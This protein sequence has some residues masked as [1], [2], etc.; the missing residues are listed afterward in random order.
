MAPSAVGRDSEL[1]CA[2]KK[3]PAPVAVK[4]AYADSAI[5]LDSTHP[6]F[7]RSFVLEDHPI[8]EARTLKVRSPCELV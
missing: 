2:K 8:D 7:N 5:A 4:V 3:D 6:S 1:E